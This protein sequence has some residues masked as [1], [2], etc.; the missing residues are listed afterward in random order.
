MCIIKVP[1]FLIDSVFLSVKIQLEH[2]EC[3]QEI[4]GLPKLLIRVA[5]FHT[6]LTHNAAASR[7]VF[8]V[9]GRDIRNAILL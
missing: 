3:N 2:S 1:V 4:F 7:V 9:R 8:I 6:D 5:V